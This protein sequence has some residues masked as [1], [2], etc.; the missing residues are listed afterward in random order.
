MIVIFIPYRKRATKI[1]L[2]AGKTCQRNFGSAIFTGIIIAYKF[3]RI[4]N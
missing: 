1:L 2:P 4:L 3:F